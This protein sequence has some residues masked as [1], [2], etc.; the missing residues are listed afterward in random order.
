[1]MQINSERLVTFVSI[2]FCRAI[3]AAPLPLRYCLLILLAL[4]LR[5]FPFFL[6]KK[7]THTHSKYQS[8]DACPQPTHPD[9]RLQELPPRYECV[10]TFSGS[11]QV[12]DLTERANT[13]L[14]QV[15]ADK[16]EG[17]E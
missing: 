8:V 14:E 9:V 3:S 2:V 12:D 5:S 13:L 16:P 11:V 1:M 10:A 4:L 15:R 7:N 6:K 17:N